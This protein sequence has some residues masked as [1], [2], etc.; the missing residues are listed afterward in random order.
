VISAGTSVQESVEIIRSA[1]AT[2]AGVAIALDRQER[3]GGKTAPAFVPA[4]TASRS[5]LPPSMAVGGRLSAVQEV[6]QEFGF[7]VVS[8]ANLDALLRYLHTKGD[9][10]RAH[11]NAIDAYRRQYGT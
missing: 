4:G 8:I 11:F 3:G 5:A 7:K 1:G 10:S 6:E 2:P 9:D